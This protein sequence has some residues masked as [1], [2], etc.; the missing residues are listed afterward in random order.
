M[1]VTPTFI[2]P[3]CTTRLTGFGF[4]IPFCTRFIRKAMTP[5]P[6][7]TSIS[8][9]PP[10][11]PA[12]TS[13][14]STEQHGQKWGPVLPFAMPTSAS[15]LTARQKYTGTV[16]AN[17]GASRLIVLS[18]TTARTKMEK[19]VHLQSSGR[20]IYYGATDL[21]G[22]PQAYPISGIPFIWEP[23][24]YTSPK[25]Y[26]EALLATSNT[27]FVAAAIFKKGANRGQPIPWSARARYS[28][29]PV[30][31]STSGCEA[32]PC[33]LKAARNTSSKSNAPTPTIT[34]YINSARSDYPPGCQLPWTRW[35]ASRFSALSMKQPIQVGRRLLPIPS[36]ITTIA[37]S[38]TEP[39]PSTLKWVYNPMLLEALSVP[40]STTSP[41][42]QLFPDPS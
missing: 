20:S 8:I 30:L 26:F 27:Y 24:N 2:F 4:R 11:Q 17:Q 1:P 21:A 22:S 36:G 42:R 32:G 39:S 34:A 3:C 23:S 6:C 15:T 10:Q 5:H 12:S 9:T 31:V 41:I 28:H 14:S 19:Q 13:D 7:T 35:K 38:L 16:G 18:R 37:P 25:V 40:S 33:P 29:I